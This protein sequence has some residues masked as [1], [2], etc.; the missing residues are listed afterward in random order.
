M[1]E[2]TVTAC[3]ETVTL[4]DSGGTGPAV[5]LVHGNSHHFGS[6]NPLLANLPGDK[7]RLIGI[8]L[9]GHG[10]SPA[11]R[12]PETCY[13][14]P[15]YA[16]LLVDLVKSLAISDAVFVGHSLGGHIV[17]EALPNLP[18]ATGAFVMGTPPVA[19]PADFAEAFLPNPAAG[20][21]F[22]AEMSQQE[23]IAF[24]ALVASLPAEEAQLI[25]NSYHGT[26]PM[27][28]ASMGAS[29]MAGQ[30]RDEQAVINTSGVSTALISTTDDPLI[31]PLFFDDLETRKLN[32]RA[33]WRGG[34]QRLSGCGHWFHIQRPN[35]VSALLTDFL[36]DCHG[37]FADFSKSAQ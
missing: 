23:A 37:N 33:L 4:Y 15:G 10:K 1:Q 7:Y 27:A 31:N 17:L 25:R 20:A 26:D 14:L 36:D 28:R 29:I 12:S 11:A 3:G 32:T 18:S 13:S 6:F 24:D 21:I 34:V 16:E 35:I 19:S 22:Q 2:R 5:V 8:D 9:P 30:F